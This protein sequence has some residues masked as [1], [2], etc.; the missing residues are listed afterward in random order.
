MRRGLGILRE[1]GH[2]IVV[3]LGHPAYYA[4]FGFEQSDRYAIACEFSAPA[5]AF[6]LIGLREGALEGVRGTARYRPE[7]SEL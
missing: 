7:F 6:M 3:V 5:E 2:E 1:N 4:R